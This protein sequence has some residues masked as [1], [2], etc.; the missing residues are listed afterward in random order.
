[1]LKMATREDPGCLPFARKTRK[2]RLEI[3]WIRKF[4]EIPFEIFGVPPEV[5][6]FSRSERKLGNSEPFAYFS[7]S[8]SPRKESHAV[9]FGALQP[10]RREL[11]PGDMYQWCVSVQLLWPSVNHIRILL[12]HKCFEA[13]SCK[14]LLPYEWI[15]TLNYESYRN[16]SI[17]VSRH[18]S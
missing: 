9:F 15:T 7:C 14:W 5:L 8:Q 2:V 4:P 13:G 17:E 1:M 18:N 6:L 3:K 11:S 16:V 10:C 12:N